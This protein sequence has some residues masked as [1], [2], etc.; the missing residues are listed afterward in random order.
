VK[1]LIDGFVRFRQEV[2]P[3]MQP[4]FQMLSGGQHPR[5]LFITCSDSRIE[6]SLLMQAD[7][8]DL[9]ICRNAGNI[10]PPWGDNVGGV[11][12]TIEYAV[13]ALSVPHIVICGHSDC[14]AVKAML[15]PEKLTSMPTVAMWL[16][17]AE[18]ARRVVTESCQGCGDDEMVDRMTYE[19]VLTQIMHVS[20]HPAVAS[21]LARDAVKLHGWVYNFERGQL[22]AFDAKE[23]QF[24]ELTGENIADM[25]HATP[26]VRRVSYSLPGGVQ[27]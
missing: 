2:Y 5:A 20:T 18:S 13:Q 19:N 25:P 24:V 1:K 11:T 22:A 17:F 12:A 9:F 10:V 23:G 15:H 16:N 26:R 7:P 27:K 14:G 4:L 8:G 3:G 6:P 21:A